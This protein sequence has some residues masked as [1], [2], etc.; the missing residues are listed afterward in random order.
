MWLFALS[1][2]FSD[3]TPYHEFSL[4]YRAYPKMQSHVPSYY[5]VIMS[6]RTNI[7]SHS[8]WQFSVA[9]SC[10]TRQLVGKTSLS[11]GVNYDNFN[12]RTY[13]FLLSEISAKASLNLWQRI[14]VGKLHATDLGKY[15]GTITS[16]LPFAHE[17]FLMK[18][19]AVT[20]I[21]SPYFSV[22][23]AYLTDK[24]GKKSK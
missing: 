18:I 24:N 3:P 4:S 12:F 13:F 14:A 2:L 7:C 6:G 20:Q 1:A 8:Y 11:I 19:T 23:S 10:R 17:Q 16:N 5:L 22:T 21:E 15:L 9:R